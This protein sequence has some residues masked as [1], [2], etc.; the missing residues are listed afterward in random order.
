M[1]DASLTQINAVSV[2]AVGNKLLEEELSLSDDLLQVNDEKLKNHL[3]TYFFSSFN[4]PEYHNFDIEANAANS[5]Y[6]LVKEIF[7]EPS[8]LHDRSIDLAKHLYEVSQ[9]HHIKPGE[10]FVGHFSQVVIERK[11]YDVVG[12]FKCETKELFL[13]LKKEANISR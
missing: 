2:H 9:H 10:L 11:S 1:V 12:L 5:V 7:A 6:T 3:L 4:S 13:K 8:S